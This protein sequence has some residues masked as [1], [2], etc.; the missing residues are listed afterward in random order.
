M[1]GED[2]LEKVKQLDSTA[3]EFAFW[4]PDEIIHERL[5][6]HSNCGNCYSVAKTFVSTAIGMLWDEGKLDVNDPILKFFGKI[7][8]MDSRWEAV[9]VDCALRHRIGFEE[10][11]LDIDVEDVNA[12]PTDD[13]LKII[14]SHPLPLEPDSEYRYSDAAFYLLARLVE[15][16][17]GKDVEL[18]LA[19]RL[20]RPA[21]FREYAW[22]RCPLGHPIG[23]TGLYLRADDMVKLGAIYACGGVYEGKRYLSGEWIRLA[24]ERQ[25]ELHPHNPFEETENPE[26]MAKGGMYGQMLMIHKTQPI[27]LAWHANRMD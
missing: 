12:Y 21:H 6:P 11:F 13:Y 18:F 10:G 25:Y 26:W 24:Y 3:Y 8:G 1:T 16:V 20:F 7:P 2:F 4:S 9:T 23:A 5:L 15:R 22:S 19:E 14:L 17:A 27:A